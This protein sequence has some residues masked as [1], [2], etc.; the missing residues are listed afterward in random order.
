MNDFESGDQAKATPIMNSNDI[1]HPLNRRRLA[2]N[3]AIH[4]RVETWKTEIPD[5]GDIVKEAEVF[6]R[7]L[8]HGD[9]PVRRIA[10]SE[11]EPLIGLDT[12]ETAWGLIANAYGGDWNSAPDDWHKAA[13][14]WR[15]EHWHP[16]LRHEAD[17]GDE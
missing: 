6:D 10:D 9:T 14:Q 1:T 11:D 5:A 12:L 13:E 2:L 7:W 17:S 4:V 15:D 3:M 8:I 16:A